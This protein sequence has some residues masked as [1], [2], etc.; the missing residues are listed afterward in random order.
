M[1]LGS[2]RASKLAILL[3]LA[4]VAVSA[5]AQPADT[6]Y[7]TYYQF[8]FSLG[9][10]YQ[11]LKPFG[12][13]STDYN[14]FE[15]SAVARYPLPKRPRI[16]PLVQLGMIKFDSLDIADPE[17][18][19]HNHWY[20]ALGMAYA[21]RFT[22][23]FEVAADVSVGVSEAVFP[24][25][26]P[27]EPRGAL[28][29]LGA[30]GAR[31]SL[32]PSYNLSIDVHPNLKYL[33]SFSPLGRFNGFIL[34]IGFAASYRFGEDP[35][36]PQGIIRSIRFSELEIPPLFAAMQNY[37]VQH[38]LGQ[39]TITNTES[40]AL[41]DVDVAFFQAGFMDSPT[42][43]VTISELPSGESRSIDL[44]ASYNQQVFTTEGITPLTGEVIAEYIS[45]NKAA[46]QRFSVSYDLHDKTAL[47]WDDDRKVAAFITPADSALRNYS[48][49]IR[50]SCKDEVIS[51]LSETL[52]TGMQ[53][54]N[55]L[56]E[57]GCLYQVDP[58]SPF[59]A[60]QEN[61]MLVDSISLPRD[62]LKRAT[63]DCD[64]LTVLYCSILETVGIETAYITVPG[65]IYAAFNTKVPSR[66]Y[67]SVHPDSNMTLNVNGELWLP[68]EI[69]MIGTDDFLSAWRR[70][71][72][73][74][75]ALEQEPERRNL[76]FTRE[77]QKL[78]RPVGLRETDLGLQYGSKAAIVAG[79]KR[80]REKLVDSVLEDYL[81]S[82]RDSGEKRNYNKLGI[83]CAQFGRYAQAEKAFNTA[84]SLDR[85]Y[86]NPR[87][88]LGN[89]AYL[90]Q[91]YQDALRYYHGAEKVL[92]ERK[93]QSSQAYL[94][95]LL[96]ISK[97]YY[98]LENYDRATLY[99]DQLVAIAPSM[100]E[101]FTYLSSSGGDTRAA[102]IGGFEAVLYAEE[103][104]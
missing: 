35:D 64:D 47:T 14:V 60:A 97:A 36:A 83:A 21:S 101:R 30:L 79:F 48:S 38:P 7:N 96:N 10:E 87:I 53:V 54:F 80:D 42:K 22:K 76:C 88:N 19:D 90:R 84:L 93:A 91:E 44:V 56:T 69:T 71:I 67:K 26:D 1:K 39:L 73:Q 9:V 18:W 65:H 20:G 49:F 99:Y 17:R 24:N 61:T 103:E 92:L 55:A 70:G 102:R 31:I 81:S 41:Q 100:A 46:T 62:T 40:Y 6:D 29:L 63:G 77:A 66:Q 45:R 52:Q 74:Y 27:S 75:A 51:G 33:R 95:V 94:N 104:E 34:G 57:I 59:T 11:S 37:Y 12:T 43:L 16:Q 82:A 68:V 23:N 98:E 32:D 58:T 78:Y 15:L 28:T 13:Y 5:P 50:Q 72:E 3:L 85:N 8:P 4:V 86:L 25:L 2:V 89:V